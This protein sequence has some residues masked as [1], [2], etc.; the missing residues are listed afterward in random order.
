[1]LYRYYDKLPQIAASAFI[2][3]SADVI[4][5]VRIGAES[6]VWFHCTL[7]GDGEKILIGERSN[8]QDNSVLHISSGKLPCIIGNDVTVGH[9]CLVH[10]CT[11]E[12]F[13]FIGMGATVLDGAKVESFGFVAAGALVSPGFIVPSHTLV[14]G[15]PAKIIRELKESEVEMIRHVAALYRDNGR[16][17]REGLTAL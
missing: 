3:P 10:A 11:L 1:M 12:D 14:A 17:F 7:R 6:S 15:V 5:D 4:G 9:G 2:A 16:K 13:A 8:I